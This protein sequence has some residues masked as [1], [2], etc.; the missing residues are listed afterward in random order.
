MVSASEQFS[1]GAMVALGTALE[2]SPEDTS[3]VFL[4]SGLE[5]DSEA[6]VRD[7]G[8]S[9][10]ASIDVIET[11]EWTR[12]LPIVGR[13]AADTWSRLFVGDFPLDDDTRVIYLDA[14]TLTRGPIDDLFHLDLRGWPFA[15]RTDPVIQTHGLRGPDW[16]VWSETDPDGPYLNTGV[17]V[18]DVGVWRRRGVT[19]AAVELI[20]GETDQ[21]DYV[22]QDVMNVVAEGRWTALDPVWHE[23]VEGTER[24][25]DGII[26]HFSGAV[27]PWEITRSRGPLDDEY[28][29]AVDRL[30]GPADPDRR[31][32]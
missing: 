24:S 6:A 3:G 31:S 29:A 7:L 12:A 18:I 19:E 2:H 16:M 21:L 13:Y 17:L 20:S 32:A 14:D 26:I 11:D 5:P 8:R 30:L 28:L 25:S 23:I 27:K 1:R 4:T 22:D 15:A 10:R 9:L